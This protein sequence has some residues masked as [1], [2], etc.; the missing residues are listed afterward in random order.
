M[1]NLT[2]YGVKI[3]LKDRSL[4]TS[5]PLVAT[6]FEESGES[7]EVGRGQEETET[8]RNIYGI[9]VTRTILHEEDLNTNCTNYPTE[10]FI[11]YKECDD[12]FITRSYPS[13]QQVG[14]RCY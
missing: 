1:K 6:I 13:S 12:E 3:F 11:T 8:F 7:V 4:H 10:R 5:R 2:E 9:T 14:R